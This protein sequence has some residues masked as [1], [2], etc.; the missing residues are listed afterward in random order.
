MSIPAYQK[1]IR[2]KSTTASS[3]SWVLVPGVSATLNH[4]GDVIDDTNFTSTGWRSRIRGL[5]DW[6]I[7]LPSNYD[8]NDGSLAIIRNAWIQGTNIDVQYYP[9]GLSGGGFQGVAIVETFNLSGAVA[10]LESVEVNLQSNGPLS[11]V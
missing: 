1:K 5:N 11:T 2:V 9:A 7:N 10:D 8:P 6:S 3:T 4:A